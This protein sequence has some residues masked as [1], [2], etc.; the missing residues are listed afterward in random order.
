VIACD[1]TST[2]YIGKRPADAGADGVAPPAT[3]TPLITDLSAPGQITYD[4]KRRQLVVPQVESN[5]LY[6]QQIPAG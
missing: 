1:E 3:F 6:I 2:V 5:A 4:R